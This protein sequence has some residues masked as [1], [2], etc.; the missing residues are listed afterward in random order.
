MKILITEKQFKDLKNLTKKYYVG[1]SKIHGKGTFA[2]KDL[3]EGEEIGEAHT[4][5][6]PFYDYDFT[7]LGKYHNHSDNPSC[8]NVLKD[9]K[10]KSLYWNPLDGRHETSFGKLWNQQVTSVSV[11]GARFSSVSLAQGMIGE[12][13]I[14]K[15]LVSLV[16]EC[17]LMALIFNLVG[18]L[19]DTV[20]VEF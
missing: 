14:W 19:L 4:I 2:A 20:Y 1:D 3:D 11:P 16:I 18:K 6:V 10:F 17:G 8:H 13:I 7:E 12:G 15:G 9:N 5:N